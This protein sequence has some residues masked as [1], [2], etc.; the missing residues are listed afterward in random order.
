M[1]KLAEKYYDNDR[2]YLYIPVSWREEFNITRDTI[3]G[4]D[5]ENDVI[6]IDKNVER[7]Y[8]QR[9]SKKGVLTIPLNL[10]QKLS[11]KIYNIYIV[12]AEEK[13]ILK[14]DE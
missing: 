6:I 3:V 4:I 10:R 12:H 11:H 9:L 1:F 8:T 7:E 14:Q 2:G 13:V 5:C